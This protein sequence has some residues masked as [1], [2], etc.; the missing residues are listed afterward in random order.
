MNSYTWSGPG[1]L[2]G[3]NSYSIL[4]NTAGTYTRIT[5]N[6]IGQVET[7]TFVVASNLNPSLTVASSSTIICDGQAPVTITVGGLANYTWTPATSLSSSFGSTVAASPSLTTSYT[8]QG[9]MNWCRASTVLTIFANPIPQMTIT[10][11][12]Q[13]ICSGSNTTLSVAGNLNYLWFPGAL[14]GSSV[15]VAP[16]VLTTYTLMGFDNLNCTR[17]ATISVDV[18]DQPTISVTV[19]TPSVCEGNP[20]VMNASG[21]TMFNYQPGNMSGP[22]VTVAPLVSTVFTVSGSNW[23]CVDTKT[24]MVTVEALPPTAIS[25]NQTLVC[26]GDS[27]ILNGNGAY[28]YLWSTNETGSSILVSPLVNT[29]YSLTGTNQNGCSSSASYTVE[30]SECTGL[31]NQTKSA[32]LII[33]PNPTDGV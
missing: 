3:V 21:A 22:S 23:N 25:G 12:S 14:T 20:A 8:V 13:S 32:G 6:C 11:S 29:V 31:V 24:I 15:T 4:V 27:V 33:Y 28:S 16:L 17:T 9:F 18:V 30:V 10:A 1:I 7:R 5:S 19:S 2:S 26:I